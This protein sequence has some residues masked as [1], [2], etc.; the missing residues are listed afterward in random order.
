M[1]QIKTHNDSFKVNDDQI[2]FYYENGYLVLKNVWSKEEIDIMR[3]DMNEFAKGFYTAYL[4]MQ[5][6][7]NL[8]RAHRGKKLCDIADSIFKARGIPIGATAFFYKPN[9]PLENGANWHQDNCNVHTPGD[10]YINVAVAIDSADE[11]NGALIVIPK[12]HKLG[13]LPAVSQPNFAL[14]ESGR[15]YSKYP[16][17][18]PCGI[19]DGYEIK[20]LKYDSGDV[21]VL[22]AQTIHK[23]NKNEH[24]TKWRRTIYFMY[25]E[26]NQPFWPGWTAKR[27]LL[28]R[29]DSKEFTN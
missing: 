23:T 16:I 18:N 2:D 29:Y 25:N 5:Y 14:D 17:G 21:V 7:K 10:T 4:D 11:T 28:D 27:E 8:K 15:K 12:S 24:P 6:Y 3:E 26:E 20:Q 9:N 13:D 1:K 19:P 22:H